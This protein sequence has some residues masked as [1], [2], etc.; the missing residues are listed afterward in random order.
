MKVYKTT[1]SYEL[2]TLTDAKLSKEE[3][4][5]I[6]YNI[7]ANLNSYNMLN[8]NGRLAVCSQEI[9]V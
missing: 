5:R 8:S 3:L 4:D 2:E 7:Q 1:I 6:R 9:E